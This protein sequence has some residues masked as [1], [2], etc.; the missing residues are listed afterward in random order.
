MTIQD[1]K[2]L[3][4]FFTSRVRDHMGQGTW[5]LGINGNLLQ[6]IFLISGEQKS[7]E[8]HE[9]LQIRKKHTQGKGTLK[10]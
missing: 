1:N 3:N 4:L 9:Q 5:K 7:K 2:E 8:V 6:T 10:S